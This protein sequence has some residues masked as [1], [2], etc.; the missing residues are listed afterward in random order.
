MSNNNDND[1]VI[2]L[3]VM[4]R[5]D[6]PVERVINAVI[7][8]ELENIVVIGEKGDEY[9]F[10]SSLGKPQNTLWLIEIAKRILMRDD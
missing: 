9:F 10:Y 4:T 2:I 7:K 1:N 5:L 3:P 6:I 8:D